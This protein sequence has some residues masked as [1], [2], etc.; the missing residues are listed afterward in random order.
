MP[1]PT[2]HPHRVVLHNEIHAR[3][4][5]PMAAPLALS[6]LVMAGDAATREASRAHLAALLHDHHLPEPAPGITHVRVDVAGFRVRWELHTEFVTWTFSRAVAAEDFDGREP[7][8]AAQA[9]PQD[10]LAALPGETLAA[11]HL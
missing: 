11:L 10:W 8:T 1:Q 7:P 2:A 3:P 5:V 4:P 9:V 6:H